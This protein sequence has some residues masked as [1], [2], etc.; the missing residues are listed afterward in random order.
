M[1][2]KVTTLTREDY[3]RAILLRE[4]VTDYIL[5]DALDG[6][7]REAEWT[8]MHAAFSTTNTGALSE[9]CA[10]LGRDF[11]FTEPGQVLK[12]LSRE[13]RVKLDD[14]SYAALLKRT[15]GTRLYARA[16]LEAN[17]SETPFD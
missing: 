15:P 14:V 9:L 4:A 12:S 6:I 16:V 3:N 17:I 13:Q 2:K 10:D 8:Q 5:A 7:Y 1:T 11:D